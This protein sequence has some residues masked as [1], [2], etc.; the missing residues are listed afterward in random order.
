VERHAAF[1]RTARAGTARLRRL[2]LGLAVLAACAALPRTVHAQAGAGTDV[3]TGTVTGPD[4]QPVPDANIEATSLESQVTRRA[5]TDGHGRFTIL[6]PDGGGQYRMTARAV[7]MAPRI[8][9]L[10]RYADE[11]RLVW[12][13]RLEGGTV[14][15]DAINVTAGPQLL[16][17]P[18]GPTP[19]STERALNLDQVARLPVDNTDLA[20]LTTLVPGVLTIGATDT[21]AT[22]F[23]VAGL[24]TDA[25]ALTLDGLLFGTSSIPQEGLRQTRI[26]TSTYDVSRGQFS[27]GLIASTTR[28]G[29]NMLQGS[30]QYQL[31]DEDLSITSDSSAYAQ[32][33]TQ[34]VLSGGLG[35]PIVRDR[36][37]VFGSLQA[38]LRTDPQQTLA[39]ATPADLVRLGVSPDSVA[40]FYAILQQLGVPAFSVPPSATRSSDN[41]SGLVR[42][43]YVVSNAHTLTLRGDWQGSGQDPTRLGATALPQ[44]GGELSTSG[45]GVM[46]TLTS[47]FGATAINEL[48]AYL[49]ADSRDGT[50]YSPVPSGRVTVAS[51]LPDGTQGVTTLVFGGNPGLPASNTART[52]QL[53]DEVSWLPG[54]GG[55]RL[56]LGGFYYA[57]RTSDFT[58]S[59]QFGTFTFNSLADLEN[60]VAAAFRRTLNVPE[61]LS[62]SQRWGAYLG[63]V[64]MLRRHVQ[65]T[66]GARVEGSA[67]SDPP[68][69][70]PAVD[71]TFGRRTDRLPREW[72]LSPRAGFSWS[73]GGA[74]PGGGGGFAGRATPPT[75]VIRG[76]LGEFRSQP[77]SGIVSQARVASGVGQSAS[78]LYC[79][80]AVAPVPTPDWG[81]YWADSTTIPTSCLNG[82]GGG[83]PGAAR[84]IVV[85]GD[86]FEAARAWRASLGVERRLTPLF[87]LTLDGSVAYGVAQAG[88]RDLNLDATPAFQLADEGG[89]PVYVPA[90]AIGPGGTPQYLASRVDP[91]FG[92]VL[93]A[94][95]GL[96]SRSA[97]VTVGLGGIVGRGILLQTSYT[98]QNAFDELTGARGGST[99]A[100]PNTAEWARSDLERRHSFLATVTYPLSRSVEVTS[101]A[102][103]T[104]GAPFTPMVGGDVNG[105]GVRNDR[106]FIFAA[107]G[108]TPA[109]QGMQRLLA[110]ASGSVRACLEAQTGSVAARSSCTGPWQSSLDFQVNWR[111][112][113]LS[114]NRRMT[115]SLVTVNFLRGL[116]ELLHGAD[117]AHGWGLATRPDGTLL[118]VTGFDTVAQR[119]VYSVNERFGATDGSATAVRPPFQIGIQVR[120][121]IGPDRAQQAMD[122]MRAGGGRGAGGGAMGMGATGAFGMPSF[123]PDDIIRRIEAALPN[124]AAVAL[125]MR[126]SLRLDSAQVRLLEPVRDSLDRTDRV[127]LDS[128]R[129]V[130]G[131]HGGHPSANQLVEMLPTLRP[132]FEAVRNSH[133][134]A[135]TTVR[136]ILRPEQFDLLP[137]TVKNPRAGFGPGMRGGGAGGGGGPRPRP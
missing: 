17:A 92:L 130:L 46:G 58:A 115:M 68:A 112:T 85:F 123:T 71:S 106:A 87:R 9:L 135:L 38:R 89:R 116:D 101:I 2:A 33:F 43:D 129:V 80:G 23:S 42:L 86:G 19:G 81:G 26:V 63:D 136:A 16:R 45:G 70:N 34:N 125:T 57:D 21:T 109:G 90:A 47:R 93:E 134:A 29:S 30:S 132:V 128:A 12:N 73:L 62:R 24:G 67:Y 35:G 31:R 60:G 131:R 61:R 104:S 6:F 100:D 111:P 49:H 99:A 56:K 65:L 51:D 107:G 117:G 114:L 113:L 41:L 48:S 76:G 75:T 11:D 94:Y 25:N 4:G 105:D 102:R 95:S 32:G 77:P 40:R 127:W 78:D 53:T 3:L 118:Y 22:A 37:F 110:T 1:P 91:A 121:A 119:Y 108:A 28:S 55:H 122:A 137:E 74:S 82:G 13:V 8:A 133:L 69:Y 39:S 66:Y 52:L 18:E 44:T 79:T 64:W 14:T 88:Y 5:R 50:T 96:R 15:L 120:V 72:Q 124:P 54:S 126:D 10:A 98:W 27:G 97:Q 103:V 83:G 36:L 7:G 20:L 59:N 84:A